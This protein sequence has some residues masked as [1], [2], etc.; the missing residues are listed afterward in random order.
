MH[1]YIFYLHNSWLSAIEASTDT[2]KPRIIIGIQVHASHILMTMLRSYIAC[3]EITVST[4]HL[5]VGSQSGLVS[6]HLLLSVEGLSSPVLE[7]VWFLSLMLT[8]HVLQQR[9]RG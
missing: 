4:L 9:R 5:L 2:V 8:Q 7:L 6:Q 1:Y 3:F